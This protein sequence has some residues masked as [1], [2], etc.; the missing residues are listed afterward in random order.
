MA[1]LRAI[2]EYDGRKLNWLVRELLL[3]GL[4]Q[5]RERYPR[6]GAN[7]L[8]DPAQTNVRPL[9]GEAAPRELNKPRSAAP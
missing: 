2:A 5:Y 1:R 3:L 8:D 9:F 7:P 4:D 6:S